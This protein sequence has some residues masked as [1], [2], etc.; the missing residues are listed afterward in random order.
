MVEENPRNVVHVNIV[1][2]RADSPEEAFDKAEELG[3][4]N[5]HTYLNPNHKTVTFT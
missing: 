5:E 2:V 1:L 3:R 4:E